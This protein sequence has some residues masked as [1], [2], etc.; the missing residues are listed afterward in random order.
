MGVL[1]R[2]KS[3]QRMSSAGGRLITTPMMVRMDSVER[4]IF[5]GRGLYLKEYDYTRG[6]EFGECD[7]R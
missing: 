5:G 6:N 3:L 2:P 7:A 1:R 4:H